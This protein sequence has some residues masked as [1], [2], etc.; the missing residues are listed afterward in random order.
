VSEERGNLLGEFIESFLRNEGISVYALSKRMGVSHSTIGDII[1]GKALHP[2]NR[3]L[4]ALSR[5]TRTEFHVL[6]GL[7]T[8]KAIHEYSPEAKIIANAFDNLPPTYQQLLMA[9]AR[10]FE[11]VAFKESEGSEGEGQGG[12]GQSVKKRRKVNR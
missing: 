10:E 8:P 9:M 5:E 11:G 2:T 7:T 6:A 4:E 1:H 12:G 3:I